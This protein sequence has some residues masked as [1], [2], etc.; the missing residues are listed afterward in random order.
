[1]ALTKSKK[2]KRQKPFIF[3]C[4]SNKAKKRQIL[5]AILFITIGINLL[6]FLQT[7]PSDFISSRISNDNL[8]LL[9]ESLKTAFTALAGIGTALIVICLLLLSFVLVFGGLIRLFI[10]FNKKKSTNSHRKEI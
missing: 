1:M 6:L 5:E 4:K 9:Y 8:V 2:N 3:R 7:L 10:Y